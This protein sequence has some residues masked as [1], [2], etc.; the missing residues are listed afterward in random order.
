MGNMWLRDLP[1]ILR[2]HIGRGLAGLE[3]VA[4]WETRARSSGGL[5]QV[6]GIIWHHTAS[7][8]SSD[9]A[10]DARYVATGGPTPP[11]S[12]LY[13]DRKGVVWVVAAGAA[14]HAGK[15]GPVS[16]TSPAPWLPKDDANRHTIGI[17]MANDGVGEVW[18][19]ELLLAA[20]T[21]GAVLTRHYKLSLDR[22]IGHRDWCG[23]GT[24]TPGRKIDPSGPWAD[25][26]AWPRGTTWG[27]F[28][29]PLTTF[30]SLIA[31]RIA[32]LDHDE[33]DP[34]VTPPQPPPPVRPAELFT[35]VLPGDSYWAIARRI[36]GHSNSELVQ[37]LMS[38]N[39]DRQLRSGEYIRLVGRAVYP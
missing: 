36:Y 26:L 19:V 12:Q 13:I 3:T 16:P 6:R 29:S 39:Q 37:E 14:N 27:P 24:S 2:P 22:N 4:G 33:A 8:P 35:M 23:P 9:G 11:I 32:Q 5:D 21:V 7:K 15:G 38:T 28:G 34:P 20:I 25:A 17:E 30:R 18:P 10:R 31:Q 1:E